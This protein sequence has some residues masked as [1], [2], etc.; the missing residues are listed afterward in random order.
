[1]TRFRNDSIIYTSFGSPYHLKVYSF[2]RK[3][4]WNELPFVSSHVSLYCFWV[5]SQQLYM[6]LKINKYL[7]H[8][9]YILFLL[10]I[11]SFLHDDND[12][13]DDDNPW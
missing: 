11:R 13:D 5:Q 9:Q 4:W 2:I 8:C 6:I 7:N 10:I 1:L 3:G 12:D